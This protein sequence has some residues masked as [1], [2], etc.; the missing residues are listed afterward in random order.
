MIAARA[1]MGLIIFSAALPALAAAAPAADLGAAL[2][3]LLDGQ[4]GAA[5]IAILPVQGLPQKEAAVVAREVEIILV[6]RNR[7]EV[8]A[9]GKDQKGA[10]LLVG[11]QAFGEGESRTLTLRLIRADTGEVLSV[12]EV[13]RFSTGKVGEDKKALRRLSD[14]LLAQ[15]STMPGNLRYQRVAIFPFENPKAGPGQDQEKTA[16]AVQKEL[17]RAFSQ[18]GF[19][20][21]E[22]QALAEVLDQSPQAAGRLLDAQALVFGKVNQAGS[23]TVITAR[24][25][26]AESGRILGSANARLPRGDVVALTSELIEERGAGEAFFRSL[27]AFGWGQFYNREPQKGWAFSL[28]GYGVLLSTLGLGALSGI[29][30]GAYEDASGKGDDVIALRE[31]A[32]LLVASTLVGAA[33]TGTVWAW[34]AA[35]ALWV[36]LQ[37]E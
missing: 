22:R 26:E 31:R 29:T 19:L 37:N 15:A 16:R 36:G 23:D 6:G 10:D 7:E 33:L 17:I 30:A 3:K 11:S 1:A 32:D 24:V 25:V 12:A 34:G 21:V 14:T 8:V 4:K 20:V 13:A 5:K 27:V 35:D 9:P 2:E 18:R 28:T